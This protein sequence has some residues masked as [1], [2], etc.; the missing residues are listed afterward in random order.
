M[1]KGHLN[2]NEISLAV[3]ISTHT[4]DIWY[5]FKRENPEHPFAKLLPE[6][7]KES[8]KAPR[9]WKQGDVWKLIDFKNRIPKGRNGVMGMVTQR[10]VKKKK[11][12]TTNGTEENNN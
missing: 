2:A 6:Y 3:G 1:K 8:E 11:E 7:T 9:Q 4:L 5:R 10:Y 12:D